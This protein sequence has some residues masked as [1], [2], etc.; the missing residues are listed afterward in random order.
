MNHNLLT[1]TLKAFIAVRK[2]TAYCE[3]IPRGER[4]YL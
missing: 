2:D 3:P 1:L 4:L